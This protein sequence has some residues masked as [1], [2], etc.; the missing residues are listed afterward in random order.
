MKKTTFVLTMLIPLACYSQQVAG[1]NF[2]QLALEAMASPSQKAKTDAS[3][4]VAEMIRQQT[5]NPNARVVVEASVIEKLPQEGCKRIE[6]VFSMPNATVLTKEGKKAFSL[7]NQLNM[8]ENGQPPENDYYAAASKKSLQEA[9]R[10]SK[11]DYSEK[12]S[13]KK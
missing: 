2:K 4:P 1:T 10:R 5:Q 9:A 12:P 11:E 7:N 3:G 6:F 13:P 8:C